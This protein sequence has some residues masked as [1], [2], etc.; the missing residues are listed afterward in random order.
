MLLTKKRAITFSE[1]L[2]AIALTVIAVLF[3]ISFLMTSVNYL[4]MVMELRTATLVLQEQVS[5]ARE[6]KFPQVQS[7]GGSFASAAASSLRDAKGTI[8]KTVYNGHPDIIK[9]TYALEWT[10]FNGR[11]QKKT[12]VTLITNCGIDK[13]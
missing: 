3:F 5:M 6:L 10:A 2:I 1:Y 8:S 13:K 11:P 9:I 12:I 4:R 7:L